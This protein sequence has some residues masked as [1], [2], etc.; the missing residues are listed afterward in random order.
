MKKRAKF[1]GIWDEFNFFRSKNRVTFIVFT[2]T[3]LWI[4][5]ILVFFAYHS[6]TFTS[7]FKDKKSYR[8]QKTVEL[9]I[10]VFLAIFS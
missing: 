7:F 8:S 3:M 10:R 4:H 2:F 1:I 5:D 6:C 9:E